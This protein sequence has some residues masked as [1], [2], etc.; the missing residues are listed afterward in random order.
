MREFTVVNKDGRNLWSIGGLGEEDDPR[1]DRHSAIQ[2]ILLGL[3]RDDQIEAKGEVGCSSALRGKKQI[4]NKPPD[5]EAAVFPD[6]DGSS[7]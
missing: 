3:A 6:A 5:E 1:E 2:E 4:K 7:I